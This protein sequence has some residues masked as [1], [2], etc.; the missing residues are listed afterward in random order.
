[1]AETTGTEQERHYNAA[2]THVLVHNPETGGMWES[3]EGYLPTALKRGWELAAP[4]DE[5][6]EPG[7]EAGFDPG[8]HTVEEVNAYLAEHAE[9]ADEVARVLAVESEGKDRKTV[10]APD[11][12]PGD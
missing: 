11:P 1:M 3:P 7:D 8:N 6:A 4:V 9:D 5:D 10:A 2:G 12:N